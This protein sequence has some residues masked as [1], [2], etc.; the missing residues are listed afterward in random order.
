MFRHGPDWANGC[1]HIYKRESKAREGKGRTPLGYPP[2]RCSQTGAL[3][4]ASGVLFKAPLPH[5]PPHGV[6]DTE[7]KRHGFTVSGFSGGWPMRWSRGI[8]PLKRKPGRRGEARDDVHVLTLVHLE[9]EDVEGGTNITP[10]AQHVIGTKP[11]QCVYRRATGTPRLGM[12][13]H[14]SAALAGYP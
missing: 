4:K 10:F 12:T 7:N 5:P 11:S 8:P 14:G 2:A 13:T 6:G 1:T 9:L 3:W